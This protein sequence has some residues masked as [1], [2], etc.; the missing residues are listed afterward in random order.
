MGG[1]FENVPYAPAAWTCVVEV[2]GG[3]RGGEVGDVGE[4]AAGSGVRVRRV[5]PVE[6][7]VVGSL[8]A[9]VEGGV[10]GGVS[11]EAS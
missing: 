7:G 3:V 9:E 6:G 4:K 2:R 11:A 8:S 1:R 10:E 5:E